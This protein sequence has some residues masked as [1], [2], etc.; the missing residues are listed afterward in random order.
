MVKAMFPLHIEALISYSNYEKEVCATKPLKDNGSVHTLQHLPGGG[1]S[2]CELTRL[3]HGAG[4]GVSSLP[5]RT[6][7]VPSESTISTCQ[8]VRSG[9]HTHTT[10]L[11]GHFPNIKLFFT[12][13][14]S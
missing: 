4:L 13:F 2:S 1:L 14:F 11:K 9:D 6:N 5:E 12:V 3:A 10:R 7:S 8:L